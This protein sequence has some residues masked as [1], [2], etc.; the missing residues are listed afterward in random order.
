MSHNKCPQNGKN[1]DKSERTREEERNAFGL[2]IGGW[3]H[4]M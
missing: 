1:E 3:P 4:P 2:R